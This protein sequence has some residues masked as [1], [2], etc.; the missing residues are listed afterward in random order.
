MRLINY[1][2][3]AVVAAAV[4]GMLLP[5]AVLSA[6]ELP[7]P[8][9]DESSG[10]TTVVD[11]TLGPNNV[12]RGNLVDTAG[13]PAVGVNVFIARGGRVLAAGRSNDQGAFAVANLAGGKYQVAAG[14]RTIDV[15]CW[16]GKAAPPN[17][18]A[19]TLIQVNDIQRGQIHPGTCML[20]NPWIVAGVVA[21]AVLIPVTIKGLRDG[22]DADGTGGAAG[23]VIDPATPAGTTPVQAADQ[24]AS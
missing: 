11:V 8:T 9:T 20:A 5:T 21:A 4:I 23:T 24:I 3:N 15:R 18:V 19:S 13:Q 2:Q 6:D 1:M 10:N 22:D 12:L 14:D 17:A 16:T 7:Q